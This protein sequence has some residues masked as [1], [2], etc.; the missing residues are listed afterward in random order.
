MDSTI[1]I[2]WF[3]R[4]LR[5]ED[6]TALHAAISSGKKVLPV[7]IFDK[8]ILDRL[9]DQADRRVQFL[10]N[11]LAQMK[12]ECRSLGGDIYIGYGTPEEIWMKLTSTFPISEVYTNE[13]YEPYG[14]QRDH[15]IKK[16]L[17]TQGITFKSYQDHVVFKPGDILKDD[18]KPYTVFT[19]F[20][21]KWKL[22]LHQKPLKEVLPNP[23]PEAFLQTSCAFPTPEHIGFRFEPL[24]FSNPLIP[25][26]IIEKYHQTR[27]F[28][29]IEGTTH[30]GV[31]LRFGTISV[32]NLVRS[33]L[34]LNETYLNEL[35]WREFYMHILYHFPHVTERCFNPAYDR[36]Q[37]RNVPEEFEKW[38]EGKTGIPIVDA[39]MRELRSTGYMHNRVRMITASFLTKNLLINWRWGEAWFASQLMDFELA[40]NNGGWQWSAGCGTDAAPYFRVFNPLLQ[41][42]KFDPQHIYIKKWVPEFGTAHY[43]RPM[44]DLGLSRTRCL[45]TYKLGLASV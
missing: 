13:D 2:H 33:A 42:E 14:I 18:G 8:N 7:F 30:L 29:G 37:W 31:H 43:P 17:E 9:E 40:S 38:K 5:W 34:R 25:E 19:P 15:T 11:R 21:K 10:Y 4:D 45:E 26:K 39:G 12:E 22:L 41:T 16:Q 35:I 36:I 6:N 3:R 24:S 23:N 32:R 1:A 20:S 27:D 44:V 28:P